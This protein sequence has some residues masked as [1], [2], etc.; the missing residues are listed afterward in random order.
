M[1]LRLQFIVLMLLLFAACESPLQEQGGGPP[2][3]LL[4]V[5]D[6]LGYADLGCYG[7]DIETPNLDK[8][9]AEGIL[10]TNFHTSP[11]CAPTRA[12]LLSGNDNHIAGMGRQGK[13][14]DEFGYE[15]MLT[16]RIATLPE[17][18]RDAGYHTYMAGK[19]HL[20]VTEEA[21]PFNKG[22]ENTFANLGS[23]GN[24]YNSTGLFA[25]IPVSRYTE[26]G[27]SVNWPEGRYS[28]DLFTDRLIGFIDANR[29]DG[30]PFFAYAAYT[31]PHWPLQVD[32]EYWKKY[33]GR[34]DD[35]YEVLR[36]QR[37][38]SLKAAGIIPEDAILPALH[39]S[40]LPCDSLTPDQKKKESRKM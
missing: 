31:S 13:V 29:G 26:N 35:G 27:D 25:S 22:F 38:K 36:V 6:D 12:M 5:A 32:E 24:H 3:I 37:L 4:I 7:G 34:Y 16:N 30:R 11:Y 18:L 19:W 15:G 14:S 1:L 39:P 10:F 20:G 21:D 23:S 40:V 8:L 28:T 17:V 9:A 2:N 33:R